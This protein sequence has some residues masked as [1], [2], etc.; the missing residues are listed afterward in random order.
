M[1]LFNPPLAAVTASAEP[2]LAEMAVD[3]VLPHHLDRE[4]LF[5]LKVAADGTYNAVLG[6]R[7]G[8]YEFHI[9][10]HLMMTAVTAVLVVLTFWFVSRRVR[11]KGTGIDA[12]QTKGSFAQLFETM[13][14]FIRDEVV[15]PN[16]GDLTDKYIPYIWSIFFF[17]LFANVLGLFPLVM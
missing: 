5:S 16:L 9:T 14:S 4:P 15:R 7:D 1:V 17:I 10:N 6:I 13:C 8:Y 2:S 12:Y 3:H 11:V